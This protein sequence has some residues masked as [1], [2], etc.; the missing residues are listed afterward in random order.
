MLLGDADQ[1]PDLQVLFGCVMTAD[2]HPT[3]C[4]ALDS[5]D[6]MDGGDLP[7]S[8]RTQESENLVSY[9]VEAY[10]VDYGEVTESN[11]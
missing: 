8:V 6:A 9:D 2:G 7:Y 11:E 4:R 1:L 5:R 3:R 10:I